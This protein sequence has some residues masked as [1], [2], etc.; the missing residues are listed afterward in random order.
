VSAQDLLAKIQLDKKVVG[1]RVRWIMPR[2]IGE[3]ISTNLPDDLVT[4]VTTL[5]FVGERR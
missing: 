2:R 4:H 1:K 5:F 3:V